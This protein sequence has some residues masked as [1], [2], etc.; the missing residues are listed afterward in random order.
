MARIVLLS[1]AS[2]KALQKTKARELYQ[3]TLFKYGLRYA[4]SLKPDKIFILSAKY[5]L[6]GLNEEIEPYDKTLVTMPVKEVKEWADKVRNQLSQVAD[7]K[8]DEF[9][10]L[11]GIN[12]RKYLIPFIANYKVPLKGL[13][14]GRQL[15]FLKAKA[16]E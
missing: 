7:L 4:E 1:C 10:F 3:S 9:V 11:A 14:I 12:Y 6:V 16:N 15:K 13:G 8:K 2:K 5:G